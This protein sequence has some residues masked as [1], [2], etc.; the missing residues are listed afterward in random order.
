MAQTQYIIE[1]NL[2][3]ALALL[4]PENRR[5]MKLMLQTGM[6]IGDALQMPRSAL[7][8]QTYWYTEQK[9]GKRRKVQ[10]SNKLR[11][12]LLKGSNSKYVFPGRL[13]G[14]RTRQAVWK[15]LQRAAEALRIKEN[16]GTHS[17]RKIFAVRLLNEYGD[18]ER[19]KRALNHD[20]VY[21]TMIYALSDK[22]CKKGS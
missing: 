12:E 2:N 1:E 15:D 4:T 7:S 9:T 11:Q 16:F 22:I 8:S 13:K 18:I 10:L 5:V 17:A 21:V 3:H 6:R 19:V 20:N 14:H